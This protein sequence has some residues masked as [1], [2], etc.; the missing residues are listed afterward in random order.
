LPG[1]G[2]RWCYGGALTPGGPQTINNHLFQ[3]I[4]VIMFFNKSDLFQA[5]VAGV[6][7]PSVPHFS[8]YSGSPNSYEEGVEYFTQKFLSLNRVTGKVVHHHVTNATDTSNVQYVMDATR[9]IVLRGNFE[10][11]GFAPARAAAADGDASFY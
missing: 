1:G 9:E 2:A 11:A 8:D 4:D 6:P 3:A 7:I 5:K 10:R